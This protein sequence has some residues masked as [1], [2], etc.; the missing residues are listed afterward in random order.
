MK[1]NFLKKYLILFLFIGF[2]PSAASAASIYLETTRDVVSAGDTFIVSVKADSENKSISSI[3]GDIS[4]SSPEDI[5]V[6]NDFGLGKSILSLWP[7][8]P[9]LSKSGGT[10]S[11]IGG[12]P[13][14]I[15]A[16]K[17]T[18]F[19]II[20]EADKE[21]VITLSPKNMAVFA[22]DGTGARVPVT[23]APLKVTVLPNDGSVASTND[24]TTL[25]ASDKQ[26]PENFSI[27]VGQ[28]ESLF[29]GKRFALFNSV[30]NQSGI[31]YYEVF[32]NNN[33]VR[34]SGSMYVLED[35]DKNNIPNLKV[36]AYDKAGNTT[37]AT[38]QKPGFA[39]FG[40]SLSFF[41]ILIVIAIVWIFVRKIKRN[42]KNVEVI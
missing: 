33:P 30:D 8:T 21:G 38:Y 2:I 13:G 11:F 12:V 17:A 41:I 5:F 42:K 1:K 7:Q 10:V 19:T 29:E 16:E 35:Q 26:D 9:A 3:E 15:T 37:T 18:L 14:G 39:I 32:E 36:I 31:S 40:F 23:V 28:E 34:R 20:V 4:L 25:V 24:W 22:S 27:T 6:V